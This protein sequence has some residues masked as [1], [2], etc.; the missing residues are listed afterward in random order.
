VIGS[1][2]L[3]EYR[4]RPV[5][6]ALRSCCRLTR[7]DVAGNGRLVQTSE[8]GALLARNVDRVLF[9]CGS[10]THL[11]GIVEDR[12]RQAAERHGRDL[13]LYLVDDYFRSR[14]GPIGGLQIG[15]NDR[16]E[17]VSTVDEPTTDGVDE[18]VRS[19]TAAG[20][21]EPATIVGI[22]G[23]STLDTTK[24][25][26]NLLANG[27]LAATYQGWDL[28]PGAAV[29][30][31]GVSTISGTGAEATRTCVMKNPHT[32]VKLGMNSEFSVFDHLVLDPDL[33]STVPRDQFFFTGMDT[34]CHCVESLAGRHRN[35]LGDAF[36]REAVE[37]TRKVFHS[38]DMMA[39]AERE[40]LMVA[41]YLGGSAIAMSHVGL[42]HPFSAG[43]SMVLGFHHGMANC[44]ALSA[45]YDYYPSERD[46]L[47]KMADRQ[48]VTIPSGVCV[49]LDDGRFRALYDATIV[50]EKPLAN[51]LGDGFRAVLTFER[52]T[53]IFQRM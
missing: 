52:V 14:P 36:S 53:S 12:R 50:H 7:W 34:F 10:L 4:N 40:R 42:V 25:V 37:L 45:L 17:Y 27:G 16:L 44:I 26:A 23:G 41:S 47:L 43:L 35:A 39:A 22:G 24:A 19:I 11:P 3:R 21:A 51:A 8:Q 15:Q 48:A 20:Y 38:E 46:E 6:S 49:G 30:K 32:G 1:G 33:T 9:G 31:I 28:I 2:R 13:V 18:L 29:H 5:S